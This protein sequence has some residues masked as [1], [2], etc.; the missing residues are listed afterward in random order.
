MRRALVVTIGAVVMLSA[1]LAYLHFASRAFEERKC[2]DGRVVDVVRP[3]P[4]LLKYSG[5]SVVA[6]LALKNALLGEIKVEER[7][8][9]EAVEATQLLDQRLRLIVIEARAT[10]CEP[11][12][13]SLLARVRE[14][15]DVDLVR[16]AARDKVLQEIA[17]TKD[18]SQ[19]ARGEGLL[20]E[21]TRDVQAIE[22]DLA[23]RAEG[24]PQ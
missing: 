1:V 4:F 2:P 7:V 15:M 11:R 14:Y 22:T 9:Q 3:Q 13:Q 10:A 20:R 17:V 16:L 24:R 18:P 6:S 19:R 21:H 23:R 8:L 12:G 5:V